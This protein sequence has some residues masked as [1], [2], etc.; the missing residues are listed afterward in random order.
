MT[1]KNESAAFPEGESQNLLK[2]NCSIHASEPFIEQYGKHFIK[3]KGNQA[4]VEKNGA[5]SVLV[6]VLFCMHLC[7]A[8]KLYSTKKDLPDG[9]C[10][11]FKVEPLLMVHL[12]IF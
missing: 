9:H 5:R 7:M 12:E 8:P 11:V 2:I 6:K 10:L 3:E 1:V 4:F